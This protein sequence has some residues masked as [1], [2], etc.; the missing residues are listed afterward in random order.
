MNFRLCCHTAASAV[1]TLGQMFSKKPPLV[2]FKQAPVGSAW[3]VP[4]PLQSGVSNW[5]NH[6][7]TGMTAVRQRSEC[8][9]ECW[10]RPM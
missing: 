5:W 4:L 9:N 1:V 3:E 6:A 2:A 10:V 8:M 7:R